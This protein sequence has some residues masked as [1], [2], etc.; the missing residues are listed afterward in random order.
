MLKALL[1]RPI[2]AEESLS[3]LPPAE[4][5]P[6]L[7]DQDAAEDLEVDVAAIHASSLRTRA[8]KRKEMVNEF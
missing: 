5:L 2:Q 1:A 8:A 4:T 6:L 7:L 3:P